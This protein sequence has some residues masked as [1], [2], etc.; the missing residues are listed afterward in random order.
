M[1]RALV[2]LLLLANGVF[3]MWSQGHLALV[4]WVPH[5]P[6]E[7]QRL[8]LQIKP[9]QVRLLNGQSPLQTPPEPGPVGETPAPSAPLAT[10]KAPEPA[11]AAGVAYPTRSCW[12]ASGFTAGQAETLRAA[13][14]PLDLP[15]GS[16]QLREN[17]DPARWLV[18]MGP[19]DDPL[20][21][22]GKRAELLA[23]RFDFHPV[24]SPGLAPG[25]SLGQ[26]ATEEKARLALQNAQREGIRTARVVLE[27]TESVRFT[28]RLPIA[29]DSERQAVADL[30]PAL[31]GQSLQACL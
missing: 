24:D 6:R 15:P 21:L 25:L 2:A 20:Q 9:E 22:E 7:P 26:Y 19:F 17:R 4:G 12:Q 3:F 28:L 1:L 31:A 13:L 14:A 18:Y 16:W 29:L 10:P 5:D 30:G 11:G 27:Q 23:L 8:Q